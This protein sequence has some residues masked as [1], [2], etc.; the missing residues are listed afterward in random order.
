MYPPQDVV[1][2]GADGLTEARK[3]ALRYSKH[4]KM[5]VV[6]HVDILDK[7]RYSKQNITVTGGRLPWK[8]RH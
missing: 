7:A 6:G 5:Q 1:L 2:T 8:I 3:R 4:G